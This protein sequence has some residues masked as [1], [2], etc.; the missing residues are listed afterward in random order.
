MTEPRPVCAEHK[1]M[2]HAVHALADS[3][4][5]YSSD[6]RWIMRIGYAVVAIGFSCLALAIMAVFQAGTLS[7]DVAHNKGD[8]VD[9]KNRVSIVEK[10][11]IEL[12][13]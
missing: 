8:I 3:L 12:E 11:F 5:D 7:A 4:R 2:L 6:Q 9:L 1:E 13:K 10:A